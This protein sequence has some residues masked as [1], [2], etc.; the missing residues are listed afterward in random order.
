[1]RVA[2]TP[3]SVIPQADRVGQNLSCAKRGD[4]FAAGHAHREQDGAQAAAV[5]IVDVGVMA[6]V[7]EMRVEAV[8]HGGLL[9]L[10]E[11]EGFAGVEHGG[12][13]D[14]GAGHPRH[15]RALVEAEAV[16]ERQVH[17]DDVAGGTCPCGWRR[18]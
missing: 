16:E 13:H 7:V 15:E 18:R 11:T 1:M 3:T 5:G 10:D 14:A 8:H 12:E 9:G 17:Q 4:G 2:P 6:Q